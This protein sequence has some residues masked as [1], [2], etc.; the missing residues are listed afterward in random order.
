MTSTTSSTP[1]PTPPFNYPV[2]WYWHC[3]RCNTNYNISV[4]RRC[5]TCSETVYVGK[6]R[7][8][9][10]ARRRRINRNNKIPLG[11]FHYEYWTMYN[12]WRRFRSAYEKDPHGWKRRTEK[13]LEG[14]VVSVIENGGLC[15]REPS[16]VSI[17]LGV[18][19]WEW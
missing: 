11:S 10:T 6:S 7:S 17:A 12:D 8:P 4:T 14:S 15:I 3:K 16:R 5:L 9:P 2:S 1:P 18:K 13:E 19:S